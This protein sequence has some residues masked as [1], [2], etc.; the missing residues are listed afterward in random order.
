MILNAGRINVNSE[1]KSQMALEAINL[2]D[3]V[4]CFNHRATGDLFINFAAY[5]KGLLDTVKHIVLA[6][7][8]YKL[9]VK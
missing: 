2:R 7:V 5:H 1:K 9:C 6:V 4:R 3:L 8:Y